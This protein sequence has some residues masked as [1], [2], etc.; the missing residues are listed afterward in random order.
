[1]SVYTLTADARRAGHNVAP[2]TYKLEKFNFFHYAAGQHRNKIKNIKM[3]FLSGPFY[4][5]AS[6]G[7]FAF[8]MNGLFGNGRSKRSQ[9]G[10]E[11]SS[12]LDLH[13]ADR[14]QMRE[15]RGRRTG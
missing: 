10:E 5:F 12:L 15:R 7:L 6:E 8:V 9:E 13:L 2:D 1:M 14:Q 4:E 11:A 3:Y